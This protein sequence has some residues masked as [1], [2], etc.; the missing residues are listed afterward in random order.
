MTNSALRLRTPDGV[1][2]AVDALS[3]G[4]PVTRVDGGREPVWRIAPE[5]EHEAAFYRNTLIHAFL[6]TSIVELALVHARR[7]EGDR[8]EAFWAQAMRLARSAEVRLLL[9]RLSGVP[10]AHRRRDVV[11]RGLG[12][13]TSRQAAS[14]STPCCVPSGH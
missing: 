14:R 1:R 2:A 9:R 6:E 10:R 3:G 5:D 7:A 4:H 11:A 13:S 8:L 12:D